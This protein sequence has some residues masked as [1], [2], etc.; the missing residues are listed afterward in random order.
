MNAV[1]SWSH[2]ARQRSSTHQL[3]VS[4]PPEK[5]ASEAS[6]IHAFQLLTQYGIVTLE[7]DYLLPYKR[8]RELR[9]LQSLQKKNLIYPTAC[10]AMLFLCDT[11]T[12]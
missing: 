7:Q 2:L 6:Q 10:V 3:S 4:L 8:K 1:S 5:R 12:T 11:L 9:L